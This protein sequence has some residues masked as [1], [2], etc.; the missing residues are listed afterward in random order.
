[1]FIFISSFY[2][3]QNLPDSIV[4]FHNGCIASR[5]HYKTADTLERIEYYKNGRTK[6]SVWLRIETLVGFRED[7]KKNGSNDSIVVRNFIPFGTEKKYYK[8]GKLFSVTYYS[9]D[10]APTRLYEYRKKGSLSAYKEDPYGLK[11][12]FNKKGT[13]TRQMDLNKKRFVSLPKEYLGPA[14]LK[15]R[16]FDRRIKQE[17][18][19]FVSGS[20]TFNLSS[21]KLVALRLS[22]DT[23]MLRHCLIE[24]FSADSV[25]ISRFSY[26]LSASKNTLAYDTTLMLPVAQIS[27][28]LYAKKSLRKIY[29]MATILEVAGF[30]MVLAPLIGVPL[31]FGATYLGNPFALGTIIAGIPVFIYSKVLLR[32]MTPKEYRMSEWKIKT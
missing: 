31:F 19:A 20:T 28:L 30:D 3:S 25:C 9:A 8:R 29:R 15:T 6:D 26:D 17:Q 12:Y 23:T 11:I 27:S 14:H 18:A 1:L 7:V 16:G 4:K 13:I 24:G 5:Y 2:F 10:T 32:K 22:S 21:G